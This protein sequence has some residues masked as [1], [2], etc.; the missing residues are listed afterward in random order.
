MKF[1]DEKIKVVENFMGTISIYFTLNL[2]KIFFAPSKK[3]SRVKFFP[4]TLFF[5]AKRPNIAKK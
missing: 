2:E 1:L 4:G 3:F 5:S